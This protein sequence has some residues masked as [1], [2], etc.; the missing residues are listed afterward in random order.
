MR[1]KVVCGECAGDNL[2]LEAQVF[3]NRDTAEWE[4]SSPHYCVCH[5]CDVSGDFDIVP[6]EETNE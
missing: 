3:W 2:Y 6:E 4:A 1:T 5:Q